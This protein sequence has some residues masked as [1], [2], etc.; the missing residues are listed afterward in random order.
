MDLMRLRLLKVMHGFITILIRAIQA[1]DSARVLPRLGILVTCQLQIHLSIN[2]FFVSS[3]LDG[4]GVLDMAAGTPFDS[5][6]DD[7]QFIIMFLTTKS[8]WT[9]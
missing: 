6:Y 5:S 9:G 8:G 7:G 4:D 2:E 1:L 3:S